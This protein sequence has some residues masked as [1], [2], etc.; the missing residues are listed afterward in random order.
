MLGGGLAGMT[1]WNTP[2]R[3]L[4]ADAGLDAVAV[5]GGRMGVAA[6]AAAPACDEDGG[7]LPELSCVLEPL[8]LAAAARA[9]AMHIHTI[10]TASTC[11]VAWAVA[12][13]HLA[14]MTPQ[15]QGSPARIKAVG[16]TRPR[17]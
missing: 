17:Y 16:D 4:A 3:P 9:M 7:C 1:R 2:G 5:D 15:Q 12:G 11:R 13:K 10:R 14:Q 6:A 8:E